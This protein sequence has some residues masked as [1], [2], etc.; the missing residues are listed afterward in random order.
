MEVVDGVHVVSDD[1]AIGDLG[2]QLLEVVIL[3]DG[4]EVLAIVGA[5][6]PGVGGGQLDVLQVLAPP[7]LP[8]H[9]LHDLNNVVTRA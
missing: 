8:H 4:L 7:L 1:L 6:R 9:L 3:D 5:A 2:L